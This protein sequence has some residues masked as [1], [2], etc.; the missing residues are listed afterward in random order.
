M[1][2]IPLQ[3]V[4]GTISMGE[5]ARYSIVVGGRHYIFSDSLRGTDSDESPT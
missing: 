5:K 4:L 2:S 1:K 3:G